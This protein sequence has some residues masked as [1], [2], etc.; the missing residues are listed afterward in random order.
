[1]KKNSST[2]QFRTLSLLPALLLLLAAPS[3]NAGSATWRLDPESNDWRN[4]DNWTPATVPNSP[5]DFATLGASNVTEISLLDSIE[6]G[7][8][9]FDSNASAFT[10]TIFL[11]NTLTFASSPGILNNSGIMQEIV[12]DGGTIDFT[13]GSPGSL[14]HFHLLGSLSK[15]RPGGTILFQSGS[16]AGSATYDIEGADGFKNQPGRVTI[17]TGASGGSATFVLHRS[18]VNGGTP[19]FLRIDGSAGAANITAEGSS[20]PGVGGAVIAFFGDAGTSIITV[21]GSAGAGGERARLDFQG[22]SPKTGAA[23]LVADGGLIRVTGFT[24]SGTARVIINAN[25]VLDMS[26]LQVSAGITIGSLEGQR[27]G[28]VFLGS[29]ELSIGSRNSETVYPGHLSDGGEA[30]GVGGSLA[31]VGTGSLTLTGDNGYTGGTS[32]SEGSLIVANHFGSGT[33]PGPVQVDAGQIGGAGTIAGTLTVG[34]GSGSG[35]ALVP[36]LKSSQRVTMAIL[37]GLTFNPDATYSYGVN[38]N[39]GMADSVV[40]NGVA[41]DPSARFVLVSQG[42]GILAQ[43]TVFIAIDNTSAA[44]ISGNFNGLTEGSTITA[45]SNTYAVSY[46]GGDGNDLTLTVQ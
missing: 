21:E 19:G 5:T 12:L 31:K 20:L 16:G 38:T 27:T 18:G 37:S 13:R 34:S 45:G 28:R 42:S 4:P 36:A 23:T 29:Q 46:A 1:M 14:V 33:G 11:G 24:A 40:A 2:L 6:L 39:Q 44:A 10:L 17:L 3:L 22:A 41:I 43:G 30:G 35:A 26:G 15:T 7:G 25:G 9:T 32:V 8:L